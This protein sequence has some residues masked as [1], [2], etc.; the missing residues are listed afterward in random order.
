MPMKTPPHPG[1]C[2][3]VTLWLMVEKNTLRDTLAE[4][5]K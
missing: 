4:V 3:S 5:P 1:A 2:P